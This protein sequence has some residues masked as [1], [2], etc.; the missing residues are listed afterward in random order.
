M[1]HINYQ[2]AQ[3][4]THRTLPA[5]DA[6]EVLPETGER[7]DVSQVFRVSVHRRQ[8]R[9]PDGLRQTK[10]QNTSRLFPGSTRCGLRLLISSDRPRFP[11]FRNQWMRIRPRPRILLRASLIILREEHSRNESYED[12]SSNP[13][14]VSTT[15][16]LAG[17]PGFLFFP[18]R[19][20]MLGSAPLRR[21]AA[22]NQNRVSKSKPGQPAQAGSK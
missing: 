22:K 21:E 10:L 4:H 16:L 19:T 1:L 12:K 6:W 11:M 8:S 13:H 15:L 9:E 17:S 2:W 7:R 14:R 3:Q 5:P 20:T 18:M